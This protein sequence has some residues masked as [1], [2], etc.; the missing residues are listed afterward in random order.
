MALIS[1]GIQLTSKAV[2]AGP[3]FAVEYSTDCVN[4]TFAG[5]VNLQTTASIDYVDI[6]ETSTCIKLQSVG[7]CEN[8][9]V[10]G[11]S[12]SSSSYNT[13]LITLTEK[14][15]AGPEFIVS[16]T[17]E[18]LFTYLDTIELAAEGARAVIEPD[19]Q[20]LAI[21]LRSNGVC[22]TSETKLISGSL[23]TPTPAPTQAPTATPVPTASPTPAPPTPT[24]V[25]PTP[26]PTGQTPTP[27]PAPTVP[28]QYYRIVACEGASECYTY[29]QPDVASQRY[30]DYSQSPVRYFTWDNVSPV[31]GDQGNPCTS[32]QKVTNE[33]GCPTVSPTPTPTPA[34]QTQNVAVRDC[35]GSQVWYVQL[36]NA[37]QFPNG[38]ALKLTSPG[39][40]LNGTRCWEIIDNDYQGSI[41]FTAVVNEVNLD[42]NGCVPAVTPTP[43]PTAPPTPT[44]APTIWY[45]R[46]VTCDDPSGLIINVSSSSPIS[47]NIVLSD[48]LDCYQYY[49][50]GGSGQNGDILNF[51]QFPSCL[52]CG[53]VTPTPVP[54]STPVPTCYP[55]SLEGPLSTSNFTCVNYTPYYM[56]TNNIC[57][58][59]TIYSG[60]G[61]TKRAPAGWYNSETTFTY[62]Y[63]NGTSFTTSCEFTACP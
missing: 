54:T 60:L 5:R 44:P 33:S 30:V 25:P 23:P 40:T 9:V 7:N 61:C 26:T 34:P 52:Q 2:N 55:A 53:S 29:I 31:N 28:L 47:T 48:G 17:T 38:F 37:S 11:S 18:S 49:S 42:C 6:E 10:S 50:A 35:N 19:P 46:F 57:T 4:Y 8:Y 20:A 12:P 36:T 63:W 43:V 22:Q 15:G 39:G 21:R 1:Y 41:D 62:R 13:H 24:P 56:D 16:E 59:S 3:S 27:T 14:N 45:A 32:I 58:A 51:Q